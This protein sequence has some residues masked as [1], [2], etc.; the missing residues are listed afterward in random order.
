[1]HKAT[2]VAFRILNPDNSLK[3]RPAVFIT[4]HQTELDIL[5]M[6]TAFPK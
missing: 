1:M 3:I 5:M 4:N 6:C 2:G